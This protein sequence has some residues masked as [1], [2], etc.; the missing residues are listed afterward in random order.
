MRILDESNFAQFRKNL[1]QV[2]S[3]IYLTPEQA[4]SLKVVIAMHTDTSVDCPCAECERQ[5]SPPVLIS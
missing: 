4:E 5:K 3:Q 1:S 2:L